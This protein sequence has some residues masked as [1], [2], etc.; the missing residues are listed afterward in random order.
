MRHLALALLLALPALAEPAKGKVPGEYKGGRYVLLVPGSWSEAKAA[1]YS[2]WMM[3]IPP[4]H[5]PDQYANIWNQLKTPTPILACIV[6]MGVQT[7]DYTGFVETLRKDYKFD[8]DRIFLAAYGEG[9]DR[10]V[11]VA[12]DVP[13]L[14]TGLVVAQGLW[15][16]EPKGGIAATPVLIVN[17]V[18]CTYAPIDKARGLKSTIEGFG[19]K[20]EVVELNDPAKKDNWPTAEMAR[21]I[22]WGTK[23]S[24]YRFDGLFS[25]AV[26][27]VKPE[28]DSAAWRPKVKDGV[29]GY[30]R[31]VGDGISPEATKAVN[32]I[33]PKVFADALKVERTLPVTAKGAVYAVGAAK[34]KKVEGALVVCESG[35]FDA[36][37][38]SVVICLGE[39][40]ATRVEGSV[41]LCKGGVTL[42]KD[43]KTSA[44]CT[45]GRLK[46]GGAV[47]QNHICAAGGFESAAAARDNWFVNTA[48]R[49]AKTNS[50]ERVRTRRRLPGAK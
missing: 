15:R 17:D 8:P 50:G 36:I 27:A 6:D 1:E 46:T 34:G 25:S 13:D 23:Q 41:V 32:A 12:T 10:G 20:A 16:T 33:V 4:T 19:G 49:K 43:L 38:D 29:L 5:A 2:L 47:E 30:F 35:E 18:G 37:V 21:M 45:L 22:E 9:A 7:G 31:Q 3:V 40:K 28:S 14:L 42:V 44:V 11:N 39:L 24:V 48:E 26:E